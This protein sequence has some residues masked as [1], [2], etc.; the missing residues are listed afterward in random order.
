MPAGEFFFNINDFNS[1]TIL[2]Y[3]GI[4][5][6][7]I[8]SGTFIIYFKS[9]IFLQNISIDY[10]NS[11]Q[12]KLIQKKIFFSACL[13]FIVFLIWVANSITNILELF[14]FTEQYRNGF[15]KG[16]GFFTVGLTQLVP[17]ALCIVLLTN[18]KL[19]HFFY[20][21]LIIVILV[22]FVLGLRIFLYPLILTTLL[23]ISIL[24]VSIKKIFFGF[25]LLLILLVGF[26]LVLNKDLPGSS[27]ELIVNKLSGRQELK[28]L[29][30]LDN[31]NILTYPDVPIYLPFS[32]SF[33]IELE[34]FKRDIVS[35]ISN[36]G[37]MIQGITNYSGVAFPLLV[38]I[39]DKYFLFYPLVVLFFIFLLHFLSL[40]IIICKKIFVKAFLLNSFV[41]LFGTLFEDLFI[42]VKLLTNIPYILIS[43]LFFYISNNNKQ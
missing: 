35:K 26:K 7:I 28:S 16:S 30:I 11:F 27:I 29:L 38:F 25:V 10:F 1:F 33:D 22:S 19:H 8:T 31:T 15:Y 5:L 3:F 36:R 2:L 18:K 21:S 42:Y 34:N 24:E 6:F 41:I 20:I 17:T 37:E 23:R 4:N 9:E 12:E 43:L 14:V 13:F 40:K 32:S 39:F